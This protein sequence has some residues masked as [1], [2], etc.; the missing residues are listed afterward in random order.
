VL[1]PP[2]EAAGAASGACGVFFLVNVLRSMDFFRALD[3]HF[4]VDPTVGGWA[5]VELVARALLGPDAAGLADDAVWRVLAELDGREPDVLPGGGFV[6]PRTEALPEWWIDLFR[7]APPAPEASPPLGMQPTAALGRFLD[8]VIP[9]IR[10]RVEAALS[11]A[12]GDPEERLEPALLRR[13]GTV[14]AT[15]THVDV[16]LDLDQATLPVRLAG[17]D[18]NPGWVPELARVVT[19]Y[20][21]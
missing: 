12:G 13:M 4:E 19:F 20:F 16:H 1:N 9:V 3:E 18:A 15:R 10:A 7:G 2:V 6:A 5:W 17:L 21:A 14:A 8:V 11:A